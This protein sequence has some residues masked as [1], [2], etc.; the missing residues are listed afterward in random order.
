MY[1][2]KLV[3]A[4]WRGWLWCSAGPR[5]GK[6][7]TQP[8]LLPWQGGWAGA[9]A[10]PPLFSP[11]PAPRFHVCQRRG[12]SERQAARSACQCPRWWVLSDQ[13][14]GGDFS[15]SDV[16]DVS[17]RKRVGSIYLYVPM[18][19]ALSWNANVLLAA[20]SFFFFNNAPPYTRVHSP[21]RGYSVS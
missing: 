10:R 5:A 12:R 19:A 1:N 14:R 9:P 3:V 21:P 4:S 15:V 16:I 7:R 18:L 11:A 17:R 13:R 20:P 6:A 2:W 8:E